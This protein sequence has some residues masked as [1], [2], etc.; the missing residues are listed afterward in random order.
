MRQ[1]ICIAMALLTEPDLLIADEPTTALDATLEVQVIRLLKE[2]QR[3]VGCS[4]LFISHHLGVVAELCDQRGH[5]VCRRGRRARHGARHLPRCRAIPIRASCSN[6]IP[7]ASPSR[8]AT[9]RPSRA[10]CPTS[11]TCRDG[12]IF[13]RA[14]RQRSSAARGA[15]RRAR[16]C[17]R[18]ISR[19]ATRRSSSRRMTP[20]LEVARSRHPLP[21]RAAGCRR[22]SRARPLRSRR[23]P[24]SPSR[25]TPGETYALV[26]ESGSGKTT[27]ARGIV[28]LVPVHAGSVVL[29]R[30]A[31]LRPAG[32]RGSG[33]SAATSA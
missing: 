31:H 6:A 10:I 33:R 29:R 17:A 7:A 14:A 32:A 26:G 15:A 12:C 18:R 5:H 11:S 8:R 22:R 21:G 28:G 13:R 3:D 27:L 24:A 25:S 4:I 19:P 9:C 1:R 16:R 2:L 30:R 20:L 23:S